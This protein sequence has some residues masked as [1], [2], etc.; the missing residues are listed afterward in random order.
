MT[1]RLHVD[2][3]AWLA[4]VE[5]TAADHPGLVPVVKGN[6]YGFGIP[7]LCAHATNLSR[8]IAVG[9]VFEARHVPPTH[10]AHVLTPLG[11]GIPADDV[12]G[13]AVLTVGSPWHVQVLAEAGWRGRVAVKL[14][15]SMQ[16]YGALPRDVGALR[17]A[18]TGA[19]LEP[20]AWSL[21]LPLDGGEERRLDEARDWLDEIDADLP[22]HV[23]HLSAESAAALRRDHPRRDVVVRLGTALWLGD[24]STMRLSADVLDVHRG[25]SGRAGYRLA[26]VPDGSAIVL[27]G[28]G[29]SHGAYPLDDGRSPFHFA[30]RRLPLIEPPHMHT[31]MLVVADGGPCPE[32]GEP[33][34]VQ[35]PLT[36]S[37]P[38]VVEWS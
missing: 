21:H 15:S 13:N 3:A 33:L 22:L 14:R 17:D 16:R 28:A 5:R 32:P 1:L 24:K 12:P 11:P 29:T 30:R 23:S 6:G 18:A 31:S 27:A 10:D 4:H 38:D 26:E 37:H 20:V 7:L 25:A 35:V 36:R 34:D 8:T 9:S 2:R 19:G